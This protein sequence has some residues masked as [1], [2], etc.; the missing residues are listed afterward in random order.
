ML[1]RRRPDPTNTPFW[2]RDGS[3]TDRSRRQNEL[4]VG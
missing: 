1:P 4:K 3:E 2:R